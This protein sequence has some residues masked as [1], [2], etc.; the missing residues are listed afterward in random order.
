[1]VKPEATRLTSPPLQMSQD[2]QGLVGKSGYGTAHRADNTAVQSESEIWGLFFSS[3]F[4]EN[5]V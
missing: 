3:S 2:A 1:M 5:K 4:F